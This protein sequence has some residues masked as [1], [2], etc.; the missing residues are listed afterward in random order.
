MG[1]QISHKIWEILRWSNGS[2]AFLGSRSFLFIGLIL[3]SW[4]LFLQ[5]W[6]LF[7]E[8]LFSC[9]FGAVRSYFYFLSFF[10]SHHFVVNV[11]SLAILSILADAGYLLTSGY[12]F[13]AHR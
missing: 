9:S 8:Y 5:H 12:F 3:Q 1:G 4:D 6:R 11:L 2:M 7:P 13:N 10:C